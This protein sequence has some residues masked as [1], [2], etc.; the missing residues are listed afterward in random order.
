MH[1]VE[2]GRYALAEILNQP[3]AWEA[4]LQL[5]VKQVIPLRALCEDIQE[6]IFTGCGSGLNVAWSAAPAFQRFT[7]IPA[8]AVLSADC[9]CFPETVFSENRSLVVRISRPAETTETLKACAEAQGRGAKTLAI[10]CTPRSKLT[11]MAD[12]SL[13]LEAAHEEAVVTT[14]SLASMVL[15]GQVMAALVSGKDEYLEQLNKL[16]AQGKTVVENT[17]QVG[18]ELAQIPRIER[19]AFVGNCPYYGLARECQLKIKEMTLLPCDSYPVFDFRHGPKSNINAQM[20]V[21][22][23]LSDA[24]RGAEI[25]FLEEMKGL[26]GLVLVLCDKAGSQINTLADVVVEVDSGLPDCARD[27]PYMPVVYFLAFYRS[28]LEGQDSDYPANLDYAVILD[29]DPSI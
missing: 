28:L 3:E 5:V 22:L 25:A 18:Q 6:V 1:D 26:G 2:R 8:R 21:T 10:T 19:F 29:E 13:V 12:I 7:G 17:H 23:L 9:V 11:A 27:I 14:Q 16:P 24:A 20:L 15:C 4:T